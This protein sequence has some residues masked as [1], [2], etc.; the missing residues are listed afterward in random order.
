MECQ[1]TFTKIMYPSLVTWDVC[2]IMEIKNNENNV[3]FWDF[4]SVCLSDPLIVA[5]CWGFQT[6][7]PELS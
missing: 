2:E 1:F 3:Y 7:N 6:I 5:V 4:S